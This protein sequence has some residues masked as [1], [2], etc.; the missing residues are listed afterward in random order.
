[1]SEQKSIHVDVFSD[2]ACPYCFVGKRRFEEAVAKSGIPVDITFHSYQ[3]DPSVKVNG[4][5]NEAYNYRRWGGSGWIIGLKEEAKIDGLTFKNWDIWANT[6]KAHRLVKYCQKNYPQ[7]VNPLIESLFYEYFENGKNISLIEV[8]NDISMNIGLPDVTEML[9][10]NEM[11]REVL[12]EDRYAK[13]ELDIHGVPYYIID[14][15]YSLEGAASPNSFINI[16]KKVQ[17]K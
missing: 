9:I 4:E 17:K 5:D 3:I 13:D 12:T 14:N 11:K 8:L 2:F 15:K 7:L 1:M 10:G 16:F 6:F